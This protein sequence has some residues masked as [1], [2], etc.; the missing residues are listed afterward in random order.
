MNDEFCFL[1]HTHTHTHKYRSKTLK[2]EKKKTKFTPSFRVLSSRTEHNGDEPRQRPQTLDRANSAH[3]DTRSPWKSG[4]DAATT[5]ENP[6]FPRLLRPQGAE[7]TRPIG[8]STRDS[9][10]QTTCP[11]APEKKEER[12]RNSK[13]SQRRRCPPQ[14]LGVESAPLER[15][16]SETNSAVRDLTADSFSCFY[17]RRAGLY[18]VDT[19]GVI[20]RH[21][22][23]VYSVPPQSGRRISCIS[24]GRSRSLK[25]PVGAIL[26]RWTSIITGRRTFNVRHGPHHRFLLDFFQET[27][28]HFYL[29]FYAAWQTDRSGPSLSTPFRVANPSNRRPGTRGAFGAQTTAKHSA[30]R[31]AG[32]CLGKGRSLPSLGPGLN[33]IFLLSCPLMDRV[34]ANRQMP[35]RASAFNRD[36]GWTSPLV[37]G[38]S[39]FFFS[40]CAFMFLLRCQL[41]G[42]YLRLIG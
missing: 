4:V 19:D 15:C 7:A 37:R 5:A 20:P 30:S 35:P 17:I 32:P 2:S 13:R 25:R 42:V 26:A 29:S 9:P 36:P 10:V 11:G 6:G 1:L 34:F 39:V 23:A 22:P 3:S 21:P 33:P 31:D 8:P 27:G 40:L 38:G 12:K 14:S 41:V 28:M 18:L 16:V 24:F